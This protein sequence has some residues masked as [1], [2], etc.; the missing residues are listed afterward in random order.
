[1]EMKKE[2]QHNLLKTISIILSIGMALGINALSM[3]I[4]KDESS[5]KQ[6]M[7]GNLAE[8]VILVGV[9][10]LWAKVLPRIF[11]GADDFSFRK[12]TTY[13]VL[14]ILGISLLSLMLVYRLIY[15]IRGG[16]TNVAMLP[17]IYSKTEFRED[18]M[19]SIHAILIAPV[20]EE[21]CYRLIPASVIQ[22]RKNRIVTLTVLTVIFALMHPS[23]IWAA[24]VDATVFCV[25]LLVTHNPL[26]SILCHAFGNFLKTV[27]LALAYF[28]VIDLSM[29][30]GRGTIIL[31]SMP[32]T[33]F[34]IIIAVVFILPAV[35]KSICK[36]N[37]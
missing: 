2:K 21:T 19:A 12:L 17:V 10:L 36:R 28:D 3:L 32:V 7:I 15:L 4:I 25:L 37:S 23:N 20:I 34:S 29:A 14:M 24:L 11:P 35:L 30:E 5:F 16:A 13:Q 26:A 22:T 27:A 6:I 1:M 33:L 9:L 8:M 18:M 31:F